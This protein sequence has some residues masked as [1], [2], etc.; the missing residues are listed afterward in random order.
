MQGFNLSKYDSSAEALLEASKKDSILAIHVRLTDYKY[1]RDFGILGSRYYE[2]ALKVAFSKTNFTKIWLFSDEPGLASDM[3]PQKYRDLVFVI[4]D[5]GKPPAYTLQLMRSCSG[6]II[7]N[8]T[9]SWW[10]AR[11]SR[12]SEPL[13]I[14]PAVWFVGAQ[15]PNDLVPQ[16]WIRL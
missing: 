15:E 1:E 10:G 6:Y 9:F 7:A 2:E 16:N 8:S 14:A 5:N 3:L 4:D 12:T 13:V 11:L